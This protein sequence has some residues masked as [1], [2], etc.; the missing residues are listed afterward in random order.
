MMPFSEKLSAKRYMTLQN[1]SIL[2]IHAGLLLLFSFLHVKL[3]VFVNVF[4]ILCYCVCF[5]LVKKERMM[6]YVYVTIVEILFH[7]FMAIWCL[8]FASGFQFYYIGCVPFAMC[9]EYC[10]VH[11]GTKPINAK[12]MSAACTM[13]FVFSMIFD[14]MHIPMYALNERTLF[15]MAVANASLVFGLNISLY[16]LLTEIVSNFE[17]K[18]SQMASCDSLTGLVNR[19]YLT[20]YMSDRFQAGDV[21]NYWI[22]ILDI[23]DFKMVNDQHGHL[24]G[25]FV[26]CSLAE[27]LRESCGDRIVCRWGGEE[28]M[29]VGIN[30]EQENEAGVLLERVRG[31]IAAKEFVYRESVKLHL[32]V[33]IGVAHYRN[34]QT[35]DAL[36]NTADMRLYSGKQTGKNQVI[37]A[38]V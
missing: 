8:G 20:Q 15:V 26:L 16:G 14:R 13:M 32:T 17:T 18:L 29:I 1:I 21:E 10:S 7:A 9:A 6:E 19:H 5:V 24:C 2:A 38:D 34:G 23:D 25:D 33:T 12:K 28:F 37:A 27:I 36:I 31:A 11:I 35:L 22:A 3:M 30:P 4:S